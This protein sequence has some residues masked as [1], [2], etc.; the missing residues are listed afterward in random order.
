MHDVG[1]AALEGSDG[2]FAGV[3]GGG[4]S[5][6]EADGVGMVAGLCEGDAV[7]RGVELSVP[8]SAE[9]VSFAVPGPHGQGGGAVVSGEGMSGLEPADAG[10]LADE[11]RRR[12]CADP[13]N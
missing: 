11:L 3:A 4:S 10:D 8:S 5:L 9:T 6:D 2:F 12:Q 1:E 7:Q 13:R